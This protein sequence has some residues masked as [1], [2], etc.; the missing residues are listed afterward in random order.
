MRRNVSGEALKAGASV[1]PRRAG[2]PLMVEAGGGEF[3]GA[4]VL[5]MLTP[6]AYIRPLRRAAASA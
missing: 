2:E 4:R 1:T 3:S 5:T 6:E